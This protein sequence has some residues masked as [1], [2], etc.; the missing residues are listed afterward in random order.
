MKTTVR[1][2]IAAVGLMLLAG[3]I[4]A[5]LRQWWLMALLWAGS[6]GCGVAALNF[7][8]RKDE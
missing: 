7:K 6:L 1:L 8:N 5:F 4:F 2:L 3:V